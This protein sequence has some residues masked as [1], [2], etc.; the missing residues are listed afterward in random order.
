MIRVAPAFH[1]TE[2]PMGP[3]YPE[4][5]R[6]SAILGAEAPVHSEAFADQSRIVA[7]G[8]V[9]LIACERTGG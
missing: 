7:A 1:H 5:H 3:G 4:R 8:G 2:H 9:G 6:R